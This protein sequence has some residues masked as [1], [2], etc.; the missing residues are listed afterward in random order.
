[1]KKESFLVRLVLNAIAFLI[2]SSMY[3]GMTVRGLWSALI[4]ALLWGIINA[5]LRP[6]LFLLTL[7][8]NF[9]TFGLFTFVI[10]GIILLVTASLYDGLYL[11]GFFAG[12]IA[13]FL[14]SVVNT[15]LSVLL[16]KED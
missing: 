3:G 16:V 7:P 15:L 14:L 13:A 8:L 4:A 6:F 1:M 10:N 9:A 2:V 11:S 5:L 12:I